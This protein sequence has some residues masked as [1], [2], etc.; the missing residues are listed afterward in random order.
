M[1]DD[2]ITIF[3]IMIDTNTECPS[4]TLDRKRL[5]SFISIIDI[6]FS[7]SIPSVK[8]K[9][10]NKGKLNIAQA[11]MWIAAVWDHRTPTIQERYGVI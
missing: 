5:M 11:N 2:A 4:R 1:I 10:K 8:K 3:N 9:R 7:I 6:K